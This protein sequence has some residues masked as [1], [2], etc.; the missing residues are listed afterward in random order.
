MIGNQ[1]LVGLYQGSIFYTGGVSG[2]G[3]ELKGHSLPVQCVSPEGSSFLAVV[4][5]KGPPSGRIEKGVS[6][7]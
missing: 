2:L 6:T 7:G 5:H 3:Q 1:S 4:R